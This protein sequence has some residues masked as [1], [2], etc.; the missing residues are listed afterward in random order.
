MVENVFEPLL[1]FT[2]GGKPGQKKPMTNVSCCTT[3]CCLC[4][5][6]SWCIQVEIPRT[7]NFSGI[8]EVIDRYNPL[9]ANRTLSAILCIFHKVCLYLSL[10]QF[11][12]LFLVY[13]RKLLLFLLFSVKGF[14]KPGRKTAEEKEKPPKTAAKQVCE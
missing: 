6:Q 10:F 4:F 1:F 2:Q 7:D 13:I 8:E 11:C 12:L 9:E 5:R 14:S 3:V